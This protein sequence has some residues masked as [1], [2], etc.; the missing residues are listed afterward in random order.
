GGMVAS[1]VL[2]ALLAA[3][4]IL[5]QPPI[6]AATWVLLAAAVA[7]DLVLCL[8]WQRAPPAGPVTASLS[9]TVEFLLG[10]LRSGIYVYGLTDPGWKVVIMAAA[11]ALALVLSGIA[12][13]ARPNLSALALAG[14]MMA[15][16]AQI[17]AIA[18]G[19]AGTAAIPGQVAQYGQTTV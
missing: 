10:L 1:M 7:L 12:L 18:I 3:W 8:T 4:L 6:G 16:L 17:V 15:S 11:V 5:M 14:V 9:Q 2:V 13:L 19:R